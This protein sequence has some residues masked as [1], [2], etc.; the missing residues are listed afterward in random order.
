MPQELLFELNGARVTP[1]IATFGGTSYQIANIASVHVARRKKYNPLAV[2]IFLLGLG[3]LAASMS[4]GFD[5]LPA[6]AQPAS[7]KRALLV[8]GNVTREAYGS[9][10]RS[11]GLAPK[12]SH[13]RSLRC[14]TNGGS[15]DVAVS[16]EDTSIRPGSWNTAKARDGT[17]GD[18]RDPIRVHVR[19]ARSRAAGNNKRPGPGSESP[20]FQERQGETRTRGGIAWAAEANQ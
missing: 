19:E 8:C 17:S 14:L 18:L 4:R 11:C 1:H 2:I 13:R 20:S 15:I 9:R 5:S 16:G 10:C 6:K 7:R 12:C 3:I